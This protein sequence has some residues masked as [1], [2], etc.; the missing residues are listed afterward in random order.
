MQL[1]ITRLVTADMSK[2]G[3]RKFAI[4]RGGEI[5]RNRSCS[6]TLNGPMTPGSVWTNS[7]ETCWVWQTRK[8]K[9]PKTSCP[10]SVQ[11]T[12]QKEKKK[13]DEGTREAQ[14]TSAARCLTAR[15]GFSDVK[16]PVE[17]KT[18]CQFFTCSLRGKTGNGQGC[19][20][21]EETVRKLYDGP[22][23]AGNLEISAYR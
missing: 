22:A 18:H 12:S 1:G 14:K 15:F 21:R 5:K 3:D 23:E 7:R 10:Y 20:V 11:E 2:P 9:A 17:N 13:G 6:V 16:F 8:G 4:G 19:P